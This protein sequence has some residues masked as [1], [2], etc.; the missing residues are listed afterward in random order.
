MK[1]WF[2]TITFI[3]HCCTNNNSIGYQFTQNWYII[4]INKY[5]DSGHE[6]EYHTGYVHV[7]NK[8]STENSLNTSI[9]MTRTCTQEKFEK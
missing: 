9:G 2:L 1:Y 7:T 6:N 3:A 8:S 5:Y 4:E